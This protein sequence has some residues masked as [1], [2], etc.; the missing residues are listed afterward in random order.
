[1][2]SV[3]VCA[4]TAKQKK[5]NVIELITNRLLLSTDKRFDW[6]TPAFES[7]DKE[8]KKKIYIYDK[9]YCQCK[10]LSGCTRRM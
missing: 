3:C 8:N 2:L 1:M 10:Y 7:P 6:K 5:R 4:L 9:S